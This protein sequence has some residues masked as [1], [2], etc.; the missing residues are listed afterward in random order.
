V[1]YVDA[2]AFHRPLLQAG[3]VVVYQN[4]MQAQDEVVAATS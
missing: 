1:G 4:N 2:F 3:V